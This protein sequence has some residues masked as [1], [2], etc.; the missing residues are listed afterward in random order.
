MLI[1][2]SELMFNIT[3]ELQKCHVLISVVCG[4][5]GFEKDINSHGQKLSTYDVLY[6]QVLLIGG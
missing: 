2:H 5:F 1:F 6:T 3:S 4:T